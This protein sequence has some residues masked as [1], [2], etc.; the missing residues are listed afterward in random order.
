MSTGGRLLVTS[1][2]RHAD[3]EHASGFANVLDL[4]TGSLLMRSPVPESTHRARDLNP[5]GGLRGARGIA[6]YGNKLA[7]ANTER[8]L[9][10]DNNWRLKGEITHPLMGGI[11][12]LLADAEGLWVACTSADL[13]VRMSWEGELISAWEWRADTGLCSQLG[14]GKLAKVDK[15]IDFRDPETSRSAPRNLV[16]L[17]SIYRNGDKILVSLGRIIPPHTYKRL[18]L[19]GWIGRVSQGLG[20]RRSTKRKS[21]LRPGGIPASK[22]PG[23]RFAVLEL[24]EQQKAK[25]VF[26]QSD[27]EV[28][29]H[30][31]GVFQERIMYNDT[32]RSELVSLDLE[33]GTEQRLPIPGAPGFLRGLALSGSNAFVG[34]QAPAAVYQVDL[35]RWEIK[36]EFL[37]DGIYN[38]SVYGVA[39]VPDIFDDPPAQLDLLS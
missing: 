8:V 12:D 14:F 16:H 6:F 19:A 10:F 24:D 15:G 9:V 33:K 20:L 26:S 7:L 13:L 2:V 38:E 29:N 5:R 4:N 25:L 30:N 21:G 23:S 1:I 22:R 36:R 11:H 18:V 31:V 35:E 39:L 28:P 32:N 27:I 3:L 34:S 37:L 17:N